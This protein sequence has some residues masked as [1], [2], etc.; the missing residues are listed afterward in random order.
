MKVHVI[1]VPTDTELLA[2]VTPA[3]LV[4]PSPSVMH[5]AALGCCGTT[6][7]KLSDLDASLCRGFRPGLFGSRSLQDGSRLHKSPIL[8][9]QLKR[10]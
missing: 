4:F 2:S 7:E 1:P 5:C 9:V 6:A 8:V 3:P 10:S